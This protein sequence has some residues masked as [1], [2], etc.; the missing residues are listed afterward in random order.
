[1]AIVGKIKKKC[2]YPNDDSRYD[3]TQK[4][5]KYKLKKKKDPF[6]QRRIAVRRKRK[7]KKIRKKL[8]PLGDNLD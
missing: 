1:M 2:V 4:V 6:F 5:R 8:S 7:R 3:H